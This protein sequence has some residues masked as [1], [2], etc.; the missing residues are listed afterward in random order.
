MFENSEDKN[1]YLLIQKSYNTFDDSEADRIRKK[2]DVNRFD[3]CL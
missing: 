3:I 2:K 1:S